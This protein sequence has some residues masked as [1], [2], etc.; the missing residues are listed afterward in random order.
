MKAI[1]WSTMGRRLAGPF[2]ALM[3]VIALGT[4]G[5]V[6]IE[7]WSVLDALY[8]AAI[9]I[10]TVG[11]AEVQPLSTEGRLLTMALIAV[12]LSVLW[13]GL[14]VLVGVAVAGELG[15]EWELRRME[16]RLARTTD[17]FV[18]CGFGRVGRAIAEQLRRDG[19]VVVVVDRDDNVAANVAAAGFI[20]VNGDATSDEALLRAGI[21]RA[22][23]LIAAVATDADNVFITLSAKALRPDLPV[24]AR[25]NH[26]D[27]VS[28]LRRAGATQVVSPYDM[29]GRQMARLALRPGTVAFVETLFR[30][31]RGPLL[32]E[33]RLSTG[34]PLIGRPIA[35]VRHLLPNLVL[36]AVHRDADIVV[37]P[38]AD[39][40]LAAG[41]VVAAIGDPGL[42]GRLEDVSGDDV[43]GRPEEPEIAAVAETDGGERRSW[44]AVDPSP[45]GRSAHS[46]QFGIR[47]NRSGSVEP[48][49]TLNPRSRGGRRGGLLRPH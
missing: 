8:M 25:A 46:E 31:E 17:H 14:S 32:E 27:V 45:L 28:K 16:Q 6:A 22:V 23:G 49:I 40:V 12:G 1:P 43:A 35:E 47:L 26:D 37:P 29:A 9:S 30:G 10:T 11:Y 19:H 2:I 39:F 18:L 3:V 7:G 24:V 20:P 15:K 41:D 36:V 34:S 44:S 42:L 4:A 33:I 13:Y 38:P 5:Y 48:S 21:D